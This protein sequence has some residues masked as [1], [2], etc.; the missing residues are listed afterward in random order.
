MI[1]TARHFLQAAK[2]AKTIVNQLNIILPDPHCT[3]TS[4]SCKTCKDD[5]QPVGYHASILLKPPQSAV[6]LTSSDF[7]A[8]VASQLVRDAP[9]LRPFPLR[10]L[11]LTPY[12]TNLLLLR[13]I[14]PRE[15]LRCF[16]PT[17]TSRVCSSFCPTAYLKPAY[18]KHLATS[19]VSSAQ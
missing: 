5:R 16:H 11:E 3:T 2:R 8:A 14:N 13:W 18:M 10:Q 9:T 19:S 4:P 15:W 6:A 17:R 7:H 12:D 1:F